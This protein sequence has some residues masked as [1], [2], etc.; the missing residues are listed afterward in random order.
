VMTPITKKLDLQPHVF[1]IHAS[2]VVAMIAPR[3]P[4]AKSNPVIVANS[5]SWNHWEKAF[6][7]GTYTPPTPNPIKPR[8]TAAQPIVGAEAKMMQ[9][10]VAI[11][12]QKPTTRLGPMVSE[13]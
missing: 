5:F 13:R 4:E 8:P 2:G 3:L 7:A 11:K 10:M 1:A 9:P 6:S 12:H